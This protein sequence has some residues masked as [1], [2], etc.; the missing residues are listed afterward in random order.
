[1]IK[2]SKVGA[3]DAYVIGVKEEFANDYVLVALQAHAT[4]DKS[5]PW[6][7]L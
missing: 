7:L 3:V 6:Y 4:T 5:I 1:M 2:L